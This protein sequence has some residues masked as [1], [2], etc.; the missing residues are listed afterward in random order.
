MSYGIIPFN[1]AEKIIME[2]GAERIAGSAVS[3][4]KYILEK[5]VKEIS[6][7][8]R[9]IA[10]NAKRKTILEKDVLFALEEIKGDTHEL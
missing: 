3:E 5:K 7:I 1:A 6:R 2:A 8:A 9:L 4:L 10:K